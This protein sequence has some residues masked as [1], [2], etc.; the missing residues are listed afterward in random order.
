MLIRKEEKTALI[1]NNNIVYKINLLED[2]ITIIR[3]FI[4]NND[5]LMIKSLYSYPL[6]WV[7]E[8]CSIL[9]FSE[10]CERFT[11][12]LDTYLEICALKEDKICHEEYTTFPYV[13]ECNKCKKNSLVN[14]K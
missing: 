4:N 1:I 11:S 7:L 8:K 12:E 5:N 9:D 2:G 3:Y 6:G 14:Y 13:T 10:L